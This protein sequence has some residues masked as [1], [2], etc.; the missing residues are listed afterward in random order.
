MKRVLFSI[1]AHPDDEGFGPSGTLIQEVRNG[2]DVHPLCIT[3]GDAGRDVDDCGD[4]AAVRRAEWEYAGELMGANGMEY[5]G[6][7]DGSLCNRVYHEVAGLVQAHVEDTIAGY[8]EPVEVSFLTFD[9]TGLSGHLD[10][11]AVSH[12]ATLSFLRLQEAH[13]DWTFGQLRYFC[14]PFNKSP[15]VTFR[16]YTCRRSVAL[17]KLTRVSMFQMF[18]SKNW[19]SCMPITASAMI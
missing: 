7:D 5:F 17:M 3:R 12:I 18:L 15:R 14:L 11:I 16:T 1:F 2:T 9:F 6:Y 19:P 8:D 13:A 4:L 10:H